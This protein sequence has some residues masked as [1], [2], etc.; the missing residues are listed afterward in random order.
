[1]IQQWWQSLLGR[2][3]MIVVALVVLVLAMLFKTMIWQPLQQQRSNALNS[4]KKQSEL[5]D[6]MQQRAE[7]VK[8]FDTASGHQNINDK[9]STSQRLNISARQA[10]IKIKR[11]QTVAD[12]SI[13]VWLDNADIAKVFSWLQSL[14]N[15]YGLMV[16]TITVNESTTAGLVTVRM[17]LVEE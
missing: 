4:V 17:T 12:N 2:E 16:Q 3:R 7:L 15:K 10:Q 1:M 9:H 6:W 11:F 13:Q 8:Q 14:K 5:L